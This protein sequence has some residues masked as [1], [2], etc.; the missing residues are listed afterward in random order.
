V[1][2][3]AL[4]IPVMP[5]FLSRQRGFTF[6]ETL[7]A[8]VAGLIVVGSVTVYAVAAV[9]SNAQIVAGARLLQQ[10]RHS[11][12]LVAGEIRRA[13]YYDDAAQFARAA[14]AQ[15]DIPVIRSPTCIIVRYDRDGA[16]YRGYRLAGRGDV[17]VIQSVSSRGAEPDCI[18]PAGN[19]G[20]RD[21]TDPSTINVQELSF[22]PALGAGG[23]ASTHGV[24]V[25]SQVVD[26]H[27]KAAAVSSP[28]VT[29]T[30]S[31]TMRV[32]NDIM[33]TGGCT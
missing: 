16:V 8:L 5:K 31:E 14:A 7:V 19:S 21:I 23:C 32:R 4:S 2:L 24:A 22:A 25:I 30:L 28:A 6:T 26:V 12:T 9:R 17:G 13:G 33:A 18:A 3:A 27:L 10:M 15:S 1:R 11:L 20:W 29:R